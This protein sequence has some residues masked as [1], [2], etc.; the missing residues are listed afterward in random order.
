MVFKLC[1]APVL[2]K[3]GRQTIVTLLS[4]EAEYVQLTLAAK[5]A[6]YLA[7]LLE[8]LQYPNVRPVTIYEDNQPA[9]DITNRAKTS[10]DGR[11]KHIDTR[12]RYIQQE[13]NAGNVTIKWISTNQQAADGMTKALDK[14]K[15]AEFVRQLG[16]ADCTAAVQAQNHAFTLLDRNDKPVY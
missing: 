15:H 12:F 16:L 3:S 13:L 5:E 6:S 2:F 10:S 4:T 9:I 7:K 11:T 14:V 1:G 8:E